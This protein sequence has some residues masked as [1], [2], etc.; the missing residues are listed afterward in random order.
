MQN[1][2]ARPMQIL[3]SPRSTMENVVV[4]PDT[5]PAA[6]LLPDT[7]PAA[8]RLSFAIAMRILLH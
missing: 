4:G 6:V 5:Q 3:E 2:S 1:F 7:Q 8:S